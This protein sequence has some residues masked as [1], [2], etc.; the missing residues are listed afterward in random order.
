MTRARPS[1]ARP[2]LLGLGGIALLAGLAGATVLLGVPM[3]AASARLVAPHGV[4]MTLGFLGTLIALERAVALGRWWGYGAP[5]AAGL[6]GL[7]LIGGQATIGSGLLAVAALT[8]VGMYVAFDRI[9]RSLHGTVQAVGG[10]AWLGAAVLLAAGWPPRDAYPWLAA[11]LVL[12]IAGERLELSRLGQLTDGAKRSFV[13]AGLVFGGGIGL[14]LVWLDAGIR[15]GGI[16]L[17]L[18]A[19][20]LARHDL[21]RRTVRTP[22]V[23]RFVAL[24]LLAGYAWLTVAGIGWTA[25]GSSPPVAAYDAMLHALFLGFVISMVF[26]HAPIIL[27]AVLRLPLPYHPRFYAH[28]ALLHAGLLLRIG[29]GDVLGVRALWVAGGLMGVT[30]LLVFVASSAVAVVTARVSRPGARSM[31]RRTAPATAPAAASA[32]PPRSAPPAGA[33][34]P[35]AE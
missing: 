11:F 27:P 32:S 10:A 23:T 1:P 33:P 35:R 28:L 13:A 21:A 26:G 8:Y 7:A 4:L 3:P 15:V 24:S 14:T 31:P 5:L 9:E 25:F 2:L 22:G 6:G 12:T 16:G 20:W 29:A 18:L 30:A 34:P 19:A 17:V